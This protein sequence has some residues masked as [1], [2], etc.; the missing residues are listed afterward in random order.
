MFALLVLAPDLALIAYAAG[1]RVGA[2]VYNS[3]HTYLGPAMLA[4]LAFWGLLPQAWS[5]CLIWVAHIGLDRALGL[6][7]KFESGFR[8]THLG[9]VGKRPAEV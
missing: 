1:P 8:D 9:V 3:C 5:L 4:G 6:G 7:L 2:L